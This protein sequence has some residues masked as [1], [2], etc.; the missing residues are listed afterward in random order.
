[1]AHQADLP[2]RGYMRKYK[3]LLFQVSLIPQERNQLQITDL[4]EACK[5]T[6]QSSR[7]VTGSKVPVGLTWGQQG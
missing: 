4:G 6:P 3:V 1:M 5:E 2:V 7:K